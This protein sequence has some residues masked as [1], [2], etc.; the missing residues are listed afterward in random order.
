MSRQTFASAGKC[1]EPAKAS[2]ANVSHMAFIWH[3]L[4]AQAAMQVP[5]MV[6]K[7][8]QWLTQKISSGDTISGGL[9]QLRIWQMSVCRVL[10]VA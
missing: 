6:N 7:A 10:H 4:F 8:R 5:P 3:T 9:A 1:S 2:R